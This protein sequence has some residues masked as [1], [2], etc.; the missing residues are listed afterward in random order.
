MQG[1]IQNNNNKIKRDGESLVLS[2][3]QASN[4]LSSQTPL[5]FSRSFALMRTAG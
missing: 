5:D 2:K 1:E 4:S 3:D